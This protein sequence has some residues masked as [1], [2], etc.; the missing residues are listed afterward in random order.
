MPPWQGGGNMIRN[1]TFEETTFAEAPAKFEAGTPQRSPTRSGWARRWI[2]SAGWVCPTS[3]S[4]NTNCSSMRPSNSCGS[5][6]LRL[7]GTAREKVGVLSFVLQD[8]PTEEVGR[9]LDLEGDCRPG[10]P[11]LCPTPRCGVLDWRP[12]SGHRS[13]YTTRPARST[14]WPRPSSESCGSDRRLGQDLPGSDAGGL[15]LSDRRRRAAHPRRQTPP[16]DPGPRGDLRQ[17][18][19]PRRAHGDRP[20]FGDRIERL[21]HQVGRAAHHRGHGEPQAPHPRRS[22]RRFLAGIRHLTSSWPDVRMGR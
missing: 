9:L 21:A 8:R 2:M 6:A 19:D 4:T 22:E 3:P 10:R 17:R 11:S 15:E 13:P 5:R 1:V 12:R 18:H 14:A 7:I 20:R 16:D